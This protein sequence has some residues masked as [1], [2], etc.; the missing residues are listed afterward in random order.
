M[1]K[2]E[3]FAD[4]LKENRGSENGSQNYAAENINIKD[5]DEIDI[6][7]LVMVLARRWKLILGIFD[8]I[9]YNFT[10]SNV[11]ELR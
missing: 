6:Y 4:K 7:E 11:K 8:S 1:N 5:D 10:L 9:K 2:S 3:R